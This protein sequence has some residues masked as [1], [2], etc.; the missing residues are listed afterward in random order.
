MWAN[1]GYPCGAFPDLKMARDLFVEFVY[2]GE[3]PLTIMAN[4]KL[5]REF[6]STD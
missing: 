4:E 5:P 2:E 1:G 6:K 3:K